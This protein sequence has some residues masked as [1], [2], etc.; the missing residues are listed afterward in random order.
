M[1]FSSMEILVFMAGVYFTY[2]FMKL[3]YSRMFHKPM[4][5]PLILIRWI[6]GSLPAAAFF[7][8]L[9]TITQLAS[10]D[11]KG[12]YVLFYLFLGFAWIHLCMKLVEMVF[13]LSW[14]DDVL[15]L[16]N[17]AASF[18]VICS[19]LALTFLYCGANTGD[20]PGWWCVVFA[21][22][23][24]VSA[25]IG[26][27]LLIHK[28]TNV[29]ERITVEHNTCC[30]IRFGSYLF[31]SAIILARASGGDWISMFTTIGEFLAM[32]W[33]VLVLAGTGI[34]IE[35]FYLRQEKAALERNRET[36]H[37]ASSVLLGVCYI[38]AGVLIVN[39]MPPL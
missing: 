7:L 22:G 16:N 23:L 27:G 6:L 26:L 28:F 12:I 33:P 21:G 13:D 11:V 5:K 17:R 24:G 36:N 10:W 3:W 35:Q 1:D 18:P 30:G 8:I 2:K 4:G 32:G 39:S 29:S 14:I 15:N 19:F 20:G 31:S 34:L 25:W 37:I 9:Y 38:T